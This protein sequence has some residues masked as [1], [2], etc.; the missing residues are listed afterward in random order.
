MY[1]KLEHN[2]ILFLRICLTLTILSHSLSLNNCHVLRLLPPPRLFP[3]WWFFP[4]AAGACGAFGALSA[5]GVVAD[6]AAAGFELKRLP[7]MLPKR[8]RLNC[9]VLEAFSPR[10]VDCCD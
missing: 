6:A 9:G 10:M 1:Q 8:P 7:N 3:R 4:L 5:A 2:S